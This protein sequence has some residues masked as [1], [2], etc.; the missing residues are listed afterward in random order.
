MSLALEAISIAKNG[1]V[2]RVVSVISKELFEKDPEAR[3]NLLIG[4][5]ITVEAGIRQGW[6][7]F[8]KDKKDNF[9]IEC[10]GT[11]APAGD[12]A[13][14]LGFTAENLARLIED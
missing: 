12:V 11:S 9:S 2:V 7:G 6:E 14:Q 10:F 3:K 13:K 1:D 8:V 5:I 4:R